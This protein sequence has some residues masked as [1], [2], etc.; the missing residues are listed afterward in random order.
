MWDEWCIDVTDWPRYCFCPV[1]GSDI[2][3][4]MNMIRDRSPGRLV[5][6]VHCDGQE[7]AERWCEDNPGWN[8]RFAQEEAGAEPS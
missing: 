5:A 7:H 8:D 4:G 6:V 2:V 1:D 3:F